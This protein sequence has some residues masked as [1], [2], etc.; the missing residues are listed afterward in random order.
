MIVVGVR[1]G[2]SGSREFL[3]RNSWGAGWGENGHVWVDESYIAWE[4]T[5]D[6]WVVTRVPSLVF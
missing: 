1:T 6:T 5:S 2:S 3:L 4:Q